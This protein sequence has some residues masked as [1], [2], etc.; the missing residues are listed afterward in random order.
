MHYKK[1]LENLSSKKKVI[2]DGNKIHRGMKSNGNGDWSGKYIKIFL[3]FK[4]LK[5]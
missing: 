3:L 5:R 2:S 1:C 4:C